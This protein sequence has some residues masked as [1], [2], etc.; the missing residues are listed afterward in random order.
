MPVMRHDG[1]REKNR[2]Q[3]PTPGCNWPVAHD[4]HPCKRARMV[5]VRACTCDHACALALTVSRCSL[6]YCLHGRK[7][8]T[9]HGG[10]LDCHAAGRTVTWA[11]PPGC[12]VRLASAATRLG[13]GRRRLWPPSRKRLRRADETI[14]RAVCP[15]P[16]SAC[17]FSPPWSFKLQ[18]PRPRLHRRFLLPLRTRIRPAR[19][20][21]L[22]I[23][24]RGR[25]RWAA[26]RRRPSSADLAGRS[27]ERVTW[28]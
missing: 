15:S 18:H 4:E 11:P 2:K 13:S 12:H 1:L 10:P 24:Q 17:A 8:G 3:A 5:S 27:L 25:A 9:V 16:S 28:H 22:Q 23:E 19:H 14:S 26:R 6:S 21:G 7:Q 20:C